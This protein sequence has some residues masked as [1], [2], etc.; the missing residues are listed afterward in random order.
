MNFKKVML[1]T[2]FST[3]LG[4][5]T[6]SAATEPS[7]KAEAKTKVVAKKEKTKVRRA[8]E[9]LGAVA[10]LA[11]GI[12]AFVY[13]KKIQKLY[14]KRKFLTKYQIESK[15]EEDGSYTF[16]YIYH[17]SKDSS[18]HCPLKEGTSGEAY[19][20][21]KLDGKHSRYYLTTKHGLEIITSQPTECCSGPFFPAPTNTDRL[22]KMEYIKG[23]FT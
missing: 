4:Q 17:G 22:V 18:S 2:I 13:R 11:T 16:F 7:Q 10:A 1:L 20:E 21:W 8:L 15:Q 14:L 5:N 6:F 23:L 3:T 9:T 12:A 19:F